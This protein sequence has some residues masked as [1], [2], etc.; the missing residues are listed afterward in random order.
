MASKTA[1]EKIE[2]EVESL[3][4]NEHIKLM[5]I[6]IRHL[7]KIESSKLKSFDWDKLY[8]IGKGLW[9]GEDAQD[10]INNLREDRI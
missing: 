2:K 3:T 5:E 8:G 4:P 6:I 7:K 9:E 1:L 10:Y